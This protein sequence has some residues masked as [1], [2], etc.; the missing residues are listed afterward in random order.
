MNKEK[1]HFIGIGGIGMSGLAR[2]LLEKKQYVSGSDLN[3]SYVTDSLLKSGA[4]VV[5]GHK[6]EQV[7][8]NATIIYSTDIKK[9]NPEY[10]VGI[11][12]NYKM[13]HRSDLLLHLMKGYKTLAVA[14]TH[15][16]TT[17]SSL[18]T[19]VIKSAG[20]DPAYAVGGMIAGL[21]SNAG[22]GD[23]DYFVAEADE[24]DG[25]F[26][27]YETFGG[28]VTN[29]DADHVSHYG[30][31]DKLV[32]SF[33]LFMKNVVSDHL[34]WCID[35]E[36]L[37]QLNPKGV[38]YG[39]DLKADLCITHFY[40]EGWSVVFDVKLGEVEY[41]D[42][43]LNLI[44][45]HNVLNGAAVFGLCLSL[46]IPENNI[47]EAFLSFGGIARRAEKKAE[48]QDILFLD[49]YAHHPT[50]I[51]TT[52]QGIK[53]A[54]NGRRLIVVYQPH[55]YS[56]TQECLGTFSH[57]LDDADEV[58]VTEIYAAGESVIPNITSQ[59]IIDEINA[60]R[61][62][63][64]Q[65]IQRKEASE[66]L[67]M[68]I[69]PHDVV[70]TLGAGDI[71][72]LSSEIED[73]LK[74]FSPKKM[75]VGLLFGGRSTEHEITFLSAAHV[76]NCLSKDLYD[77]HYFGI[78]KKGN[79]I[80]GEDV[81]ERLKRY[82][83]EGEPSQKELLPS[84][85][86]ERLQHCDVLIPVFHGPN[87]EDGTIQGFLETLD[88]A[89]VGP[90]HLSAAIAMDKAITKHLMIAHQIPTKAFV[91]INQ[92]LWGQKPQVYLE[93]I[94]NELQFP[95]YV[96][97]AHLGSTIG[98][99]KVKNFE[100]LKQIIN[101]SF[102]HDYKL[103]VEE[104]VVHVREIEFAV[105]GNEEALIF[106]PGEI[107]ADGL[108]YDFDSKYGPQ[109]MKANPKADLSYEKIK[110]G[111]SMVL[112]AYR[113][114][115]GSGMARVDLFLD[116]NQQFWINEINPIPG[117]TPISLYPKICEVNGISGKDLMNKLIILALQRKRRNKI[118]CRDR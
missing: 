77:V 5:F 59:L 107:L 73:Q 53:K 108:V 95:V 71:T 91:E 114:I 84:S 94:K 81:F 35:N 79:W 40:Q 57:I 96:K 101:Q 42:I 23:G 60:T 90:D 10:C 44:G 64:A 85:I 43:R 41:K 1:Y 2:I 97:P 56:R 38:S 9:D 14:G 104:G 52:V 118:L 11:D 16:K 58:Y 61:I 115:E 37:A 82:F 4:N 22:H 117:F 88:K 51:K 54:L 113:A 45:R 100:T 47:R 92:V 30:D 67:S 33:Q 102:Q 70:V 55:R 87:G 62:H 13:L 111:M 46:G 26:L 68:L 66:K 15:G 72:K 63:K 39:F 34:F 25:T 98:V 83:K 69:M 28:I 48:V 74:K 109:G 106:P 27:K 6:A 93:K 18:L 20:L 12:S 49:D 116:E 103:I 86:L 75:Q 76:A 89:Y 36:Y 99:Y 8:K 50:E 7:P 31:F 112:A 24:S 19:W 3:A 80:Q 32:S 17:T 65:L 110:E 21:K 29:I 78:T 105:L